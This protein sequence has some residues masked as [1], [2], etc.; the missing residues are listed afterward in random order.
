MPSK[1]V[2]AAAVHV[3]LAA[4]RSAYRFGLFVG[5]CWAQKPRAP[6]FIVCTMRTGSNLLLSYLNSVPGMSL[7]GEILHPHQMAGLRR[8]G[9]S[10]A[11][12]IRHIRYSLNRCRHERCGAKL[13]LDQLRSH[14]LDVRQL[15]EYFPSSK[16]I[17]LYRR[18]LADQYLS[19]QIARVTNQ[20]IR[21]GGK[22]AT[23]RRGKINVDR[24]D[25]L[26]YCGEVKD[27]YA[28]ALG[29]GGLGSYAVMLSYEDLVANP[30]D[31]F[32]RLLFPFLGV[33]P[34]AV[35]T[36]LEKQNIEYPAEVV[37]NYEQV[38]DLWEHPACIL[39]YH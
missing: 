22:S 15:R 33:T 17:V 37:E 18:S 38:K 24:D 28:W 27:L 26:K 2:R 21:K 6:C 16:A 10:K 32:D 7:A 19:L 12:V 30:Q 23:E 14:D 39:E 36:D 8:H 4:A 3:P 13:R 29:V 11:S 5:Y 20:W 25:F 31:I 1:L 34:S 35:T 9:I